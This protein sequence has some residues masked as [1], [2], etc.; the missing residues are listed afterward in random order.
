MEPAEAAADWFSQHGVRVLATLGVAVVVTVVARLLVRRFRRKLE[1]VSSVTQE[2]NIQRAATLTS[3]LSAAAVVVIWTLAALMVLNEVT[4]IAPLLAS[5]GVAGVA[6]GFGAQSLVRDG[7][8]GFF[9]LLENQFG[10]G[11]VVEIRSPAG[12]LSG[13]VE[14]L[15]LRVTALRDFDGTLHIIPNGNIQAVSNKSRGWARAI[16]D[17]RIAYGEDVERVRGVLDELFGELREDPVLKA[18]I[19]DGPKILGIEA[20]AE[21]AL[22]VRVVADTRPSRRW[23]V[24]RALRERIARRLDQRGVRVPA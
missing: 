18:S 14:S 19:M 9:I 15:T 8:S 6:L 17:V 22:V 5:A 11:D 10:V 3:A 7:L 12:P 4:N 24:E 21:G 2:L 23:D 1:G 16:V 20:L 13:K